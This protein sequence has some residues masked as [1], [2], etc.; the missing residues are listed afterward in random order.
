[1]IRLAVTTALLLS[2]PVLA[3][4]DLSPTE[5]L[6]ALMQSAAPMPRAED[7][8]ADAIADDLALLDRH[9]EALFPQD[10]HIALFTGPD[11]PECP[12]ARA[13]LM[14]LA[15]RMDLRVALHDTSDPTAAA[16]MQ[17]V[18]LDTV[19]SY[20]MPDRMI[21]GQMPIFILERYLTAE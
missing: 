17:A 16:L 4:E 18:T 14:A 15:N 8:Y 5:R 11:C 9:A 21:R 19:P 13:E 20:V 2:S 6:K 7:A 3:G 10:A 1:M 12:G